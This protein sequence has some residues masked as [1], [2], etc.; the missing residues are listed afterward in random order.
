MFKSRK[1]PVQKNSGTR[2]KDVL[3]IVHT[4]ILVLFNPEDLNGQRPAIGFVDRFSRFGKVYFLKT[5]NGATEKVP[6][7]FADMRR[8]GPLMYDVVGALYSN[9]IRQVFIK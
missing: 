9:E 6:S 5:R 2:A 7:F 3:G 4:D 8:Y 1:L